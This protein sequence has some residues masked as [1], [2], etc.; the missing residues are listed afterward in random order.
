[1]EPGGVVHALRAIAAVLV[2]GGIVLDLHPAPKAAVF[3]TEKTGRRLGAIDDRAFRATVRAVEAEVKIAIHEGVLTSMDQSSIETH[4]RFPT[5]ED[6]LTVIPKRRGMQLTRSLEA[7]VEHTDGPL[8]LEQQIR[9][10]R[11]RTRQG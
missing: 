5:K 6:V 11:F 3:Y 1:M 9:L 10:F 8:L 7:R 2:P 4:E